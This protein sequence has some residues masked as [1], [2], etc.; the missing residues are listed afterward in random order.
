MN[1]KDKNITNVSS[2]AFQ[3]TD[4]ISTYDSEWGL[5]SLI[6]TIVYVK[7]KIELVYIQ[8]SNMT[9]TGFELQLQPDPRIFKII[10]SCKDGK[11]HKSKRIFGK[12]ISAKDETYEF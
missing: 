2:N 1:N 9:Y 4:G 11:W 12:Y 8:H 6:D 5:P 10:Y 3:N 7:E